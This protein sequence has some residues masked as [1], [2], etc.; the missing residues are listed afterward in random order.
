MRYAP[1]AFISALTVSALTRSIRSSIR[2]TVKRRNVLRRECLN[3]VLGEAIDMTPT[4]QDKGR[5]LKIYYGTQVSRQPPTFLFFVNDRKLMHF[6]YERY[7]ENQLRLNFGFEGT[8]IRM[9]WRNP[10]Q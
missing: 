7:L 3:D 2:S 1:V 10:I 8:P 6:S 9:I 4:P 5:H